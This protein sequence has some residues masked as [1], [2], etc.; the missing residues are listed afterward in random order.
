ML[1]TMLIANST[2][3]ARRTRLD[4]KACGTTTTHRIK[5]QYTGA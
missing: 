2:Q 4:H 5:A 1:I 3:G